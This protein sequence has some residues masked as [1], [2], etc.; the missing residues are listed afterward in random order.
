MRY[1]AVA[2]DLD[3]T[4]YP[5]S[6]LY[7]RAWPIVV[8]NA[9]R[10][11][12]FSAVRLVL[13]VRARGEEYRRAIAAVGGVSPGAVFR[14]YQAALTAERL[15]ED[16]AS[17]QAFLDARFYR[18]V[19]EVFANL[20]PYRGAVRA[21]KALREGGLRLALLSDFPPKRKLELL[22][23]ESFFEVVLC[24]EDT[25]FL[26]PSREPFDFLASALETPA[27][28]I[29]YVGNSRAYDIAGAKAAGMGAALRGRSAGSAADL[30]FV[31]WGALVDFALA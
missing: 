3:G 30:R 15:G 20:K 28:E 18:A 27:S 22:G 12:A 4:L 19:D 29:L 1:S 31:V 24:S 6:A 23:L 8:A 2:F 21:L 17:I 9:R 10:F 5:S 26:K 7:R 14:K 25:G 11:A 13:R 16:P